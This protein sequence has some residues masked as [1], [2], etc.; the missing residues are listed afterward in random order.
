MGIFHVAGWGEQQM[1]A[2]LKIPTNFKRQASALDPD[3][4]D[5][6]DCNFHHVSKIIGIRRLASG[7]ARMKRYSAPKRKSDDVAVPA[8]A[9]AP[10]PREPKEQKLC[11]APEVETEQVEEDL[12]GQNGEN[13]E[14]TSKKKKKKKRK[15][16]VSSDH[17]EDGENSEPTSK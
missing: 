1:T 9:A 6:G 4:Q 2:P 3:Y 16:E 7:D 8:A 5:T 10:E 15:S 12:H 14:P 17:S 13:T 11:F